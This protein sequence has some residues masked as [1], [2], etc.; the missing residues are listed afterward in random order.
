M[1]H[2]SLIRR[3]RAHFQTGAS[4]SLNYRR[5]QLRKLRE[6]IETREQPLFDALHADL[7]K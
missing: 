2:A 5:A 6:A 3:Q 1:D 7:S 4:R